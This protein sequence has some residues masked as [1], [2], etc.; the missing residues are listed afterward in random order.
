MKKLM[1]YVNGDRVQK[2]K[3]K[4]N[5]EKNKNLLDIYLQQQQDHN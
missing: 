5:E 3:D 4:K 2:I 1:K